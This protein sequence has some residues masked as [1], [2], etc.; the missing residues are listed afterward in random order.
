MFRKLKNDGILRYTHTLYFFN[1]TGRRDIA[2]SL[3]GTLGKNLLRKLTNDGKLVC[4]VTSSLGWCTT[5]KDR[6]E[7]CPFSWCTKNNLIRI[8]KRIRVGLFF[9]VLNYNFEQNL[10]SIGRRISV[11]ADY[12]FNR[13]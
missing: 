12:H 6:L 7:T 1:V 4:R 5:K 9:Y 8:S 11:F 3:K 2:A 13:F 10:L